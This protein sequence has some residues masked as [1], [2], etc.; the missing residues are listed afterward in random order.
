VHLLRIS[1][2]GQATEERAPQETVKVG[3]L[4]HKQQV[5][6]LRGSCAF[7]CGPRFIW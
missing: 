3:M 2:I 5:P 6:K 1:A 7:E 4:L